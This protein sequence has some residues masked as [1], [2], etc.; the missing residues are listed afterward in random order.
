MRDWVGQS[1]RL[2]RGSQHFAFAY[3]CTRSQER[4][5]DPSTPTPPPQPAQPRVAL[6]K[7]HGCRQPHL[8]VRRAVASPVAVCL[9]GAVPAAGTATGSISH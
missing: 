7:G 8:Q 2:Y 6:F 1:E 3:P 9:R 4:R 5:H